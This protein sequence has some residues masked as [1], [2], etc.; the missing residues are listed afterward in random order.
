MN[1]PARISS[2]SNRTS[3]FAVANG[4]VPSERQPFSLS[5]SAISPPTF[6]QAILDGVSRPI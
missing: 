2:L 6:L 1:R 5:A 4:S 3:G